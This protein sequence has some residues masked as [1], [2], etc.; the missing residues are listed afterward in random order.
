MQKKFLLCLFTVFLVVNSG[1]CFASNDSFFEPSSTIVG[2]KIQSAIK[3]T[4]KRYTMEMYNKINRDMT[5]PQCVR[6]LGSEGRLEWESESSVG[7]MEQYVWQNEDSSR[8]ILMFLNH[9]LSSKSQF[10]LR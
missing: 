9:R 10:G 7:V 4:G 1:T 8:I 2:D 5:Y 6:I 3:Q